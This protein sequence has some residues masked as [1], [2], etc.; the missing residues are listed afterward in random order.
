M[1]TKWVECCHFI[2][3]WRRRNCAVIRSVEQLLMH[4]ATGALGII[5]REFDF[6]YLT[7]RSHS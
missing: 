2:A 3:A 6:V 7:T 5:H 4:I 1:V